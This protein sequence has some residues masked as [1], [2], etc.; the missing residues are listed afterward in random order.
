MR[1]NT[2]TNKLKLDKRER[3]TLAKAQEILQSI[4]RFADADPADYAGEAIM[5]INET[6]ASIDAPLAVNNQGE[7]VGVNA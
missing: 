2:R 7:P 4:V 6:L 1:L 3:D 5:K